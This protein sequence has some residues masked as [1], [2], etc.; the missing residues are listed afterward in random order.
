VGR[1]I[2]KL[3]DVLQPDPN[4]AILTLKEKINEMIEMLNDHEQ[5]VGSGA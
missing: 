3:E 4:M 1:L 2:K 5:R